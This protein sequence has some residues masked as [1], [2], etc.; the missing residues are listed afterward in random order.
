MPANPLSS[1]TFSLELT[2]D[3]HPNPIANSENPSPNI[4]PHTAH[5]TQTLPNKPPEKI[6]HVKAHLLNKH[7]METL[8]PAQ[9]WKEC[10]AYDAAYA[11]DTKLDKVENYLANESFPVEKQRKIGEVS[12]S[13]LFIL[14]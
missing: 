5:L 10:Q 4:T 7:A 9:T 11:P 2:H 3:G 14:I 1:Q 12:V 6:G 13:S 8:G